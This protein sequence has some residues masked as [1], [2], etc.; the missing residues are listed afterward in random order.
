[1]YMCTA[2]FGALS[3]ESSTLSHLPAGLQTN[4]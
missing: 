2:E 3:G 4:D 1:V